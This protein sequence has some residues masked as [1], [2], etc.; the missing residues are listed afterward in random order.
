M[1]TIAIFTYKRLDCLNQCI[2]SLDSKNISEILIFNDNEKKILLLEHLILTKAQK[3]MIKIYNP[4]DFGFNKR[5]FRKPFYINKVFEISKNEYV[6]LSDD[7][8]IF[9]KGAIDSHY[10]ALKKYPFSAGGI[11][12]SKLFNKISRSIL[13]GTNYGFKK[14]FFYAIGKYDENYIKSM[15]GGDVD[16]WYRIY[17]Y[18]NKNNI[19]VAFLPNAIQKVNSSKSTR[20]KTLSSID[21]KEYTIKK[22]NLNL[23]GPMYRWFKDIRDKYQWMEIVD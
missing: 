23:S 6:L 7:D 17:H 11:V 20:K 21:P 8:G 4:V 19:S 12:R 22:H 15:G 1:L 14:D 3:K 9:N 10:N 16:F 13:Q 5:N 2:Q 18:T